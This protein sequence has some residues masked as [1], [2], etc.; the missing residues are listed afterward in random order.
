MIRDSK[1]WDLS[2]GVQRAETAPKQG[3]ECGKALNHG[4]FPLSHIH[5]IIISS[6]L[7]LF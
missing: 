4:F 3:D 2:Q 7:A 6:S 5:K 1:S